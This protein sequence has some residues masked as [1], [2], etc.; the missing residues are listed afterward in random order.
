MRVR[1]TISAIFFYL[2]ISVIIGINQYI[3]LGGLSRSY[4]ITQW[5]V[6]IISVFLN[7]RYQNSYSQIGFVLSTLGGGIAMMVIIQ[8]VLFFLFGRF[9]TSNISNVKIFLLIFLGLGVV[10][11]IHWFLTRDIDS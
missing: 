2:V 7:F 6:L 11:L 1:L 5:V 10:K 9:L 4:I 8:A 3:D